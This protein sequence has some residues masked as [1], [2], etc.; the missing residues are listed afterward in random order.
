MKRDEQ[1]VLNNDS[2]HDF[3]D[4]KAPLQPKSSKEKAESKESCKPDGYI[5][6]VDAFK[7]NAPTALLRGESKQPSIKVDYE[8]DISYLTDNLRKDLKYLTFGMTN[9]FTSQFTALANGIYLAKLSDRVPVLPPFASSAHSDRKEAGY[10]TFSK[11]YDVTYLET[12]L[13]HPVQEWSNLKK[14][15]EQTAGLGEEKDE[16]FKDDKIRAKALS[17]IKREKIS[18]WSLW[19]AQMSTPGKPAGSAVQHHLGLDIDYW[20]IPQEFSHPPQE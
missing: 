16:Q 19:A 5:R 18:C 4:R 9:G 11:V 8:S 12:M 17:K 2:P 7:E 15:A 6:G 3:D 1:L 13:R 20:Q 10:L 14:S